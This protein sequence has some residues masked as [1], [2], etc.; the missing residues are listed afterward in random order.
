MKD[1]VRRSIAYI[2]F[3]LSSD[4]A[5][6]SVHDH[7]VSKAFRFDADVAPTK[8]KISFAEPETGGKVS[9]L[10]GAG[11]FTITDE[12]SGKKVSLKL[13]PGVFDG[14]DYSCNK[15]FSGTCDGKLVSI[16]DGEHNKDFQYSGG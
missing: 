6:T 11:I 2:I 10:G 7:S 4:H 16:R 14:F 1:H 12:A 15:P 8:T 5:V 3:R 13:K 9:G